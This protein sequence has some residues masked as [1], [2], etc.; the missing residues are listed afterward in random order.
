[1]TVVL[2]ATYRAFDTILAPMMLNEKPDAIISVG[3]CSTAKKI[4]VESIFNNKMEAGYADENGHDPPGWP[5]DACKP[6]DHLQP[7]FADP[8]SIVEM[9]TK[10]DIPAEVSL[11]SM[12]FV[13]NALGY[14][15]A[16]K[17]RVRRLPMKNVFIHSPYTDDFEG[18][19]DLTDGR[20]FIEKKHLYNAVDFIIRTI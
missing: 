12:T 18:R 3:L 8:V 5:I 11:N 13:C 6:I 14:N 17:I 20:I 9:L 2:P 4:R 7:T 1:M 16:R 19:V 15:I 10:A